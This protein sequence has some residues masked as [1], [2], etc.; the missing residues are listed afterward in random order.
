MCVFVYYVSIIGR[1]LK[2]GLT[3][4]DFGDLVAFA[5][6]LIIAMSMPRFFHLHNYAICILPSPTIRLTSMSFRKLNFCCHRHEKSVKPVEYF[7]ILRLL[8]IARITIQ[9]CC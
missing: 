3:S 2:R 4:S 6:A 5:I 7:D 1:L 9:I 8:Q